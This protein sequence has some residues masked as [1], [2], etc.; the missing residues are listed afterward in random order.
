V[1]EKGRKRVGEFEK[2]REIRRVG[3]ERDSRRV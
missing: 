3:E 2:A 1:F